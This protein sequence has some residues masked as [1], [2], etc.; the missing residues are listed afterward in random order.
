MFRNPKNTKT[1]TE[2]ETDSMHFYTLNAALWSAPTICTVSQSLRKATAKTAM[3][4]GFQRNTVSELKLKNRRTGSTDFRDR[5][6]QPQWVG[7][8]GQ[9]IITG[10]GIIDAHTPSVQ[11]LPF[12]CSFW[13]NVF[14]NNWLAL[15]LVTLAPPCGKSWIRHRF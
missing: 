4:G 8:G 15:P 10:G 13:Q 9:P 12:L 11:F 2:T 14:P 7:E 6:W 5:M 3:G 1:D